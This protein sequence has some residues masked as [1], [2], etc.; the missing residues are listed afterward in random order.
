LGHKNPFV[1]YLYSLLISLYSLTF[2]R[3]EFVNIGPRKTVDSSTRERCKRNR[4]SSP[5][6]SIL[7]YRSPR[8]NGPQLTNTTPETPP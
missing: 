8:I 3:S 7:I 6:G 4:F 5:I 2:H 1:P